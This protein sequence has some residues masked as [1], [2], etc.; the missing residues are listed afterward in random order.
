MKSL[1]MGFALVALAT[2][3]AACSSGDRGS[4]FYRA[5]RAADAAPTANGG[6]AMTVG[7]GVD[8]PRTN[9]GFNELVVIG[10][11]DD[12]GGRTRTTAKFFTNFPNRDED[13][14]SK[15]KIASPPAIELPRGGDL[16]AK[17]ADKLVPIPLKHTDVKAQ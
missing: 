8:V 9:M 6:L 11:S 5:H 16:R 13:E 14:Y 3:F 7:E 15:G 17:L 12:L 10:R 2:A 4:T 1:R